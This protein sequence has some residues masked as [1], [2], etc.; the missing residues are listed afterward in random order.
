[1]T[2]IYI[3]LSEHNDY[4]QHGEYFLAAFHTKPSITELASV[5]SSLDIYIGETIPEGIIFLTSLIETGI[6]TTNPKDITYFLKEI[7][8]L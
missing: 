2:A 8:L 5:C 3:L 4:N 6:V 1:M 7:P